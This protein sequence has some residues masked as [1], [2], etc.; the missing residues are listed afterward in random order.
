VLLT[1]LHCGSWNDQLVFL[2]LVIQ[3]V[4]FLQKGMLAV[5][6]NDTALYQSVYSTC[7]SYVPGRN[8]LMRLVLCTEL[9]S[10][11]YEF[12]LDLIIGHVLFSSHTIES[13]LDYS[14]KG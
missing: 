10:V 3:S 7:S 1:S 9:I 5:S 2:N 11:G 14:P 13:R 4:L 12:E 8:Y 6:R